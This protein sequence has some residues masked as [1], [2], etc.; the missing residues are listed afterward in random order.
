[1]KSG[2]IIVKLLDVIGKV[3]E[4]ICSVIAMIMVALVFAQVVLRALNLPL[5]GLEELLTF[6]TIWLYFLGGACASFTD[7]HI[8]CGLVAAVC[9][10]P[11]LVAVSQCIANTIASGLSVLILRYVVEYAQ[12]S[13]K[14]HKISALM[15]VPMPIGELI[16]F[17]GLVLMMIFTVS[18]CIRGFIALK[19]LNA[20]GGEA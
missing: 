7:S 17:I 14:M 10:N 8:E 3:C 13:I 4:I 6:P 11:K 9:K 12:Y 20:G 1:M 2:N 5:F 16:V 19:D 15:H 18:K